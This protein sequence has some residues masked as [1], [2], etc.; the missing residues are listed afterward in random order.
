MSSKIDGVPRELLERIADPDRRDRD[1]F[2]DVRA[3]LA[4]NPEENGPCPQCGGSLSTWGCNCEP[5]WPMYKPDAPVVERQ[6]VVDTDFELTGEYHADVQALMI[7]VIRLKLEL[8]P[9]ATQISWSD[10]E[11][12]YNKNEQMLRDVSKFEG[13]KG[14]VL[15]V[16]RAAKNDK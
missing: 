5:R 10:V 1:A 7:E 15:E 6:R 2:L 16:W 3:L 8:I 12:W 14:V 11:G 4:A 13:I 9:T